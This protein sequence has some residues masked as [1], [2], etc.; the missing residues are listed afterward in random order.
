MPICAAITFSSSLP[1]HLAI[2]STAIALPTRFTK[3]RPS[4]RMR[5][6]PRISA[7]LATG[8]V[9]VVPS[10]AAS[11]T[12]AAPATPAAPL[13]VSSST[14]ISPSWCHTVSSVLVAWARNSATVVR[15]RQVPSRLNE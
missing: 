6:M 12:N 14:A 7:M 9:P 13:D 8:M 10:V 4:A 1:S 2:T 15:Y 11:T 3:V 5:W